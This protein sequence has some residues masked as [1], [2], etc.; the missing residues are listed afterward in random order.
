MF[1]K[2]DL[3][4]GGESSMQISS[5]TCVGPLCELLSPLQSDFAFARTWYLSRILMSSVCVDVQPRMQGC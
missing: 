5:Y 4:V 2:C 3:S 1:A